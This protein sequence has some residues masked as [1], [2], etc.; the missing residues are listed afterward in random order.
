M[1]PIAYLQQIDNFYLQVI[2]SGILLLT[3]IAVNR[4]LSGLIKKY[5][6]KNDISMP[7]VIY[8]I[9]YFQFIL[10]I[11]FLLLLG[12]TW[13]ISFEGLSVY[14]ISFFTVAGIGL[15]ANWSI[16]SNI[17]SAIILF[18]NFP[19]RIGDRIRI[20]DG[21]NSVEGIITD[22]NMFSLLIKNDEGQLI[23]FPNNLTLQKAI[24]LIK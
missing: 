3:Y 22:L 15:F 6:R 21:D 12:I 5:G 20:M 1:N 13:D 11:F 23:T 16:L 24:V 4:I 7:R 2:I 9:K 8:T 10:A 14:F 17:T 18:F 19:Y